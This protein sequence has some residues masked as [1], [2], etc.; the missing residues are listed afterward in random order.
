MI[1]WN[2]I[3]SDSNCFTQYGHSNKKLSRA[4]E[5]S[6]DRS[7]ENISAAPWIE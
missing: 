3:Q 5:Q 7:V 1:S 6:I 4:Y 2:E